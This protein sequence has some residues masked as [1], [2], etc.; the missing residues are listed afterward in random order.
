[1]IEE[2]RCDMCRQRILID[3]C[4]ESVV[5]TCECGSNDFTRLR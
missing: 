2:W 3:G 1:M 4:D 5:F